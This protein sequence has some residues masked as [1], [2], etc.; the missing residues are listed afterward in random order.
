MKKSYVPVTLD[1]FLNE[2]KTITLKRGYGEK[3]PVVVGAN[4]PLR[5][6]VLSFVSEGKRVSKGDLKRFIAGINEGS[7]NPM[8]S[9][10]MWIQR[11]M[12][13]FIA[14]N[15]NGVTYYKLSPI[16]RRLA[17]KF[18][19]AL[20]ESVKN[21]RR[22]L[23][24][25]SPED[26]ELRRM[27]EM[28][29]EFE[30]DFS[31]KPRMPRMPRPKFRPELADDDM[32][33][34]DFDAEPAGSNIRSKYDFI[35]RT[36]GVQRPGLYDSDDNNQML[37]IRE[38]DDAC[39]DDDDDEKID[40]S[41]KRRI[42]G[43]IENI[44]AKSKLK[45]NEADEA[46]EDDEK[47]EGDDDADE[48]KFDDSDELTFDDLDLGDDDEDS[49][50]EKPEGD[51]GGE[52]EGDNDDEDKVE[53]TEFIITVDNVEE[54]IEELSALDVTAE[55]VKDEEGEP[56]ENQIKVSA[57]DWDSLKGWLEVKGVD[58]EEM[59]GGEIEV[60]DEAG[61]GDDTLGDDLNGD[62]NL[63][64]DDLGGEDNL[65]DDDM[66]S[67]DFDLGNIDFDAENDLGGLGDESD[68]EE[69][70]ET[71]QTKLSAGD[72]EVTITIK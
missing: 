63:G 10:N 3:Q 70:S 18:N 57:D 27:R 50:E 32:D 67:E 43:I 40:E 19:T 12:Q 21:I 58:I 25:N 4:A 26:V 60:E 45:L 30:R 14:E 48:K 41:T 52:G 65:G 16:G 8:A 72:K 29:D 39:C 53:I 38:G 69:S 7:K 5:N 2:S 54:A 31:R 64:D 28:D 62:D 34:D 55:E 36:R 44:K 56:I 6:Q 13:F 33:M 42:R 59:F 1:V 46:D 24:E 51:E 35:D 15:K 17:S 11:N 68:I 71:N 37:G 9:A 22:T 66:N 20:S 47:P 23:N 49:D 61:L